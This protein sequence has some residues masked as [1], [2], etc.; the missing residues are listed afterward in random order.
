MRLYE[1][2]F[3]VAAVLFGALALMQHAMRQQVHHARF[4]NQEINPWDIRYSNPLLGKYGIWTLHKQ[5]Y[6]RSGLR[7]SFLI[8]FAAFLASLAVGFWHLLYL[9]HVF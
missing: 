8:I 6:E 5:A 2:A 3:V 7:L 4:G 1:I 9:R